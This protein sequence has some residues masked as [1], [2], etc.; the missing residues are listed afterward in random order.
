[1]LK[2]KHREQLKEKGFTVVTGVLTEEECQHYIQEYI[3]W[4]ENNFDEGVFPHCRN[5]I[6]QRPVLVLVMFFCCFFRFS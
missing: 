2:Q 3:N 4:I 5:S 1:M 6:I